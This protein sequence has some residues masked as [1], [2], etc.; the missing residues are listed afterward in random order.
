MHDNLKTLLVVVIIPTIFFVTLA[1]WHFLYIRGLVS[2]LTGNISP[3]V[4]FPF[5]V[6]NI[7]LLIMYIVSMIFLYMYIKKK[8]YEKY[9]WKLH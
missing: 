4:V 9:S 2:G 3:D 8:E 6:V 5:W 1:Y 7:V